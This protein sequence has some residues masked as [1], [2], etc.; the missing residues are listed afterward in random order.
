MAMSPGRLANLDLLR[1]KEAARDIVARMDVLL[2]EQWSDDHRM[3]LHEPETWTDE[4]W[5]LWVRAVWIWQC[6]VLGRDPDD[7]GPLTADELVLLL[8]ELL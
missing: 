7:E 6:A 3:L 2:E 4:A 1:A 5:G 8:L